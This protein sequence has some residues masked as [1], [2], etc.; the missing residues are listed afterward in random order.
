M[1]NDEQIQ[2]WIETHGLATS[3]TF[4][5]YGELKQHE[6]DLLIKGLIVCLDELEHGKIAI[7]FDSIN[8]EQ[9]VAWNV[10][11]GTSL[12]FVFAGNFEDFE[13]DIKMVVLDGLE[14]LR[15]KAEYLGRY[16]SNS[17]V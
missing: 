1:F 2:H 7:F 16:R 13:E 9:A 15:Y 6:V 14:Y 5:V 4:V 10:Y 8:E 3:F 17:Y 11:Q 12:S